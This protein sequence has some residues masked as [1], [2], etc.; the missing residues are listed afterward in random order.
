MIRK[1]VQLEIF[2]SLLVFYTSAN[3]I[4]F[5]IYI[6]FYN[7]IYTCYFKIHQKIEWL[8]EFYIIACGFKWPLVN[9]RV[10]Y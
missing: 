7:T 9:S 4:L 1:N 3:I 2:T 6:L 5:I 10:S 8:M